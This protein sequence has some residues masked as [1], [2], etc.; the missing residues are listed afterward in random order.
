MD[1]PTS[2]AQAESNL[3]TL[4]DC[5]SHLAAGT[6][7][8][9]D[10]ASFSDLSRDQ[11][12]HVERT[13]ATLPHDS[14]RKVIAAAVDLLEE[15]VD[16]QFNRLFRIGLSDDEPDIRQLSIAGLWEDDTR[17]LLTD[18]I[19]VANDDESDDVRA[20]AVRHLGNALGRLID[21]GSDEELVLRI[22]DLVLAFASDEDESTVVRRRAVEAV[23]NLDQ[24]DE[25]RE[26]I[27]AA[28]EF[29]DQ[30]LEAGALLA[31]GH[32]LESRWRAVVRQA[33][34]SPDAE[35]RFEAAR[36]LGSIGSSDDVP[37]L[38]EHTLD[39][40]AD[41]RLAAIAALGEIGGPGAVRVLRNLAEQVDDSVKEAIEDAL[42]A[43]LLMADPLRVPS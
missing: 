40:D 36:A 17:S 41:V 25:T 9:G 30:A 18:L 15:S 1:T 33:A 34:S 13:W 21:E 16:Y 5:L 38:A 26:I 22:S 8:Y 4:E 12:R 3:P 29:G 19:A 24:N 7:A 42:D 23:G 14:R 28:W 35:L 10:L 20:A 39:E 32:T 43:A 6:F 2:Q 11:A 37:V 27:L 31:M